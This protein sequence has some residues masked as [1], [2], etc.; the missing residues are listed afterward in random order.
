MLFVHSVAEAVFEGY[1]KSCDDLSLGIVTNGST[2]ID[3]TKHMGCIRVTCAEIRLI[4]SVTRSSAPS[5]SGYAK[6]ASAYDSDSRAPGTST[7]MSMILLCGW[8]LAHVASTLLKALSWSA[9]IA[10]W[11]DCPSA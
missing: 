2:M 5:T 11:I 10:R 4:L 8:A 7:S 9:A 1:P 6:A 3:G